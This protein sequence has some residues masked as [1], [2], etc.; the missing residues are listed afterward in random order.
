MKSNANP[1]ELKQKGIVTEKKPDL[2]IIQ[3]KLLPQ[4]S[5]ND[6]SVEDLEVE[7]KKDDEFI[8]YYY[9]VVEGIDL[10]GSYTFWVRSLAMDL[11]RIYCLGLQY[12]TNEG[13]LDFARLFQECSSK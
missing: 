2:Y 5:Q 7:H 12:H 10:L 6:F 11:K 4:Q 9:N 13:C 8:A 3:R 1:C